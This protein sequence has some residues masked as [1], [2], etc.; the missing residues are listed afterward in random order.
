MAP[1]FMMLVNFNA[2]LAFNLARFEYDRTSY[3]VYEAANADECADDKNNAKDCICNPITQQ[4]TQ[5]RRETRWF[6]L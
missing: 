2:A 1:S 4:G 3:T 6:G 5:H